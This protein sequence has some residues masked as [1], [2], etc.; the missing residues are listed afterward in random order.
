MESAQPT[1]DDSH[2]VSAPLDFLVEVFEHA[3][4]FGELPPPKASDSG[5]GGWLTRPHDQIKLDA[6]SFSHK[7]INFLIVDKS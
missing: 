4:H 5:S 7:S 2:H 6:Q 3:R 1:G